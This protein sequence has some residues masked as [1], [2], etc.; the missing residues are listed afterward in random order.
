MTHNL[1][2]VTV[3]S[4]S[5]PILLQG[6]DMVGIAQVSKLHSLVAVCQYVHVLY[7]VLDIEYVELI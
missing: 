7:H 6:F 1:Y 4:Q 2:T 5:W 3:Q